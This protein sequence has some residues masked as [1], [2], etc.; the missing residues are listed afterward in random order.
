MY[1]MDLSQIFAQNSDELALLTAFLILIF[2]YLE[3]KKYAARMEKEEML[4][5][6]LNN[7][8]EA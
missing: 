4:D 6:F 1:L 8:Q 2:F 3:S 5:H 7:S